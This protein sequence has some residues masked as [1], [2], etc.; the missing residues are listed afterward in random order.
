MWRWSPQLIQTLSW[1]LQKIASRHAGFFYQI[2]YFHTFNYVK[3]LLSNGQVNFWVMI[4][5]PNC[6]FHL[7]KF[8]LPHISNDSRFS[9]FSLCSDILEEC[10]TSISK[11]TK[12]GSVDT[13][14]TGRKEYVSYKW[15]LREFQSV[16]A[17]E[18]SSINLTKVS[19][20]KGA[21]ST[22][23]QNKTTNL[24]STL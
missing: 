13:E 17:P 8:H 24:Y 10:S 4:I 11:M 5:K 2:L 12:F 16:R 23:L 22:F 9:V 19:H 21:G 1:L 3:S 7:H 15:K 14:V 6:N 20:P 18:R